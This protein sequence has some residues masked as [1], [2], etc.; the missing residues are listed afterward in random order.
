[1]KE[2]AGKVAVVTGGAGG[3]GQALVER[4]TDEGMSAVVADIDATLVAETTAELRDQGRD[5]I[6]VVTDVTDARV[7]RGAARRDARRVRRGRR[8]VQQRRRRLGSEGQMWEHHVNDWRWSLD[9]NVMGVGERHQRLRP[10]HARAGHRG[11]RS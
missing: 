7:A 2:F 1:M 8:A 11:R 3:I 10:H 4:F 9:V 6:G 5:V